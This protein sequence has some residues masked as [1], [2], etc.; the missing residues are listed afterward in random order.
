MPSAGSILKGQFTGLLVPAKSWSVVLIQNKYGELIL[1][2][3]RNNDMEGRKTGARR[4]R[5]DRRSI[6]GS[7]ALFWGFS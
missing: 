6:A 2:L 5:E 1:A 3:W 4:P 7:V